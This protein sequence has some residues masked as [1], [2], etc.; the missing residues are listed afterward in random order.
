MSFPKKGRKFRTV[1]G[2][3]FPNSSG[4]IAESGECNFATVIAEALQEFHGDISA[5]V[6]AVMT[7]NGAGERTGKYSLFHPLFTRCRADMDIE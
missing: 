4:R 5:A 6:K 1:F 2:K 7:Y 3:T